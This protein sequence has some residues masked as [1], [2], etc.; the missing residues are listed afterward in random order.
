MSHAS[1]VQRKF[2][3]RFLSKTH[4]R[5]LAKLFYICVIYN[6]IIVSNITNRAQHGNILIEKL[7][8]GF[9]LK[10][11]NG[12]WAN[13][14]CYKFEKILLYVMQNYIHKNW[15]VFNYKVIYNFTCDYKELR[16]LDE[17]LFSI[18]K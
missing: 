2:F 9:A 3:F 8:D 13:M 5:V 7:K 16:H 17:K 6:H 15:S 1:S 10:L 18:L 4:Y 12:K 11:K 14:F